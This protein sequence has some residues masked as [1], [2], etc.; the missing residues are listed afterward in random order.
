MNQVIRVSLLGYSKVR[1]QFRGGGC[2]IS[3]ATAIVSPRSGGGSGG[4]N[5]GGDEPILTGSTLPTRRKKKTLIK[6]YFPY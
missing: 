1:L 4:G 2:P 3:L 6:P 5:G